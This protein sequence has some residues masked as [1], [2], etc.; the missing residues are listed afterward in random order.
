V[1]Q[2][3]NTKKKY[4]HHGQIAFDL[5]VERRF[6]DDACYGD[7]NASRDK[8]VYSPV[9]GSVAWYPGADNEFVCVTRSTGGSL[10]IGHLAP[11]SR[12]D[13]ADVTAG[14]TILGSVREAVDT[15]QGE[16]AHIHIEAHESDDCSGD[17]LAFT[18]ANGFHFVGSRDFPSNP[19]KVNQWQKE[20]LVR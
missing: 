20:A 17:Q 1:C 19:K 16:Y 5:T 2:G 10:L 15:G 14:E 6:G 18:R 3:Y 8:P 4:S 7:Q 9:T 12:L 11:D 13:N